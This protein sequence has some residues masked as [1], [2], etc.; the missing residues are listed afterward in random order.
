MHSVL[1]GIIADVSSSSAAQ[2][3]PEAASL[4]SLGMSHHIL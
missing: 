3:T 4:D 1:A 2:G